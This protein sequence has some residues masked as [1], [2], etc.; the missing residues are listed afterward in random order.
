[1]KQRN[2]KKKKSEEYKAKE[3]ISNLYDDMIVKRKES[4]LNN[5]AKS[6]EK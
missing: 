3:F 2:N 6:D 1:M 4:D 5:N